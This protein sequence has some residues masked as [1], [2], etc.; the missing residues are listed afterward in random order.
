M[1]LRNASVKKALRVTESQLNKVDDAVWEALGKVLDAD[2][3]KRLKQID[4][5]Q[6]DY[7][8]FSE[9]SVQTA[10]NLTKD[11]KDNIGIISG[12]ADRG[13]DGLAEGAERRPWRRFFRRFPGPD[14]KGH[15]DW[16]RDT[17][18]AAR[19]S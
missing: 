1:L 18:I 3:L 4:L 5:Q 11:Q 8:A 19:R 13:I 7:K 9:A 15:V 2:Q 6:R 10:L 12:D 14:G 16:Q 17:R